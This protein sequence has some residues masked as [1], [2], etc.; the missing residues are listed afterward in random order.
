MAEIKA[1]T[2]TG[3][4]VNELI[5][6]D[7]MSPEEAT[8]RVLGDISNQ[9][10]LPQGATILSSSI[11]DLVFRDAQGFTH[12]VQRDGDANSPRFGQIREV[13]SDRPS[14]LPLTDQ[15]PGLSGALQG[16]INAVNQTLSGGLSP[17]S[18]GD[19]SS[20]AAIDKAERDLITQESARAQGEL[21][22]SL[23]GQGINKSTVAND[24]AANFAQALGIA[25][26]QQAKGSSERRF[27]IQKFLSQLQAG[28]GLDLIKSISGEETTR[29]TESARVGLGKEQ[30]DLTA[31]D[32]ARNFMLEW[33]KFRKSQE[34]SKLPGILSAVA[35]I[36]TSLIP[37][38]G[39]AIGGLI[40]LGSK[41]AQPTSSLPRISFGD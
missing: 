33:E 32:A 3:K 29:A 26:G 2:N 25:L 39:P 11:N 9:F 35:S 37:G 40:G 19:E 12:R 16:A 6:R 5:I 18:A 22:T 20:L 7:R 13:G 14:V 34:K 8:R 1:P 36:A 15:I 21:I 28:T 27:D 17:L 23:Y 24:A 41:A 30:L 4:K 31:E 38:A 10:V